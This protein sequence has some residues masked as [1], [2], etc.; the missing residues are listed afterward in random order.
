VSTGTALVS[1]GTA[2]VSTDMVSTGTGRIGARA[3]GRISTIIG[4]AMTAVGIGTWR[5]IG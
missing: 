2:A 3:T 5:R 1:I 4:M